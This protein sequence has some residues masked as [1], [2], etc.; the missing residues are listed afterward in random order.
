MG[1]VSFPKQR[2]VMPFHSLHGVRLLCMGRNLPQPPATLGW[3]GNQ[4]E[5]ATCICTSS[6]MDSCQLCC[7]KSAADLDPVGMPSSRLPSLCKKLVLLG[8]WAATVTLTCLLFILLLWFKQPTAQQEALVLSVHTT[9]SK[10]KQ[11][12]APKCM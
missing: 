1:T 3:L 2:W 12:L 5:H 7:A 8:P 9:A 10:A 4:R 6:H 11:C